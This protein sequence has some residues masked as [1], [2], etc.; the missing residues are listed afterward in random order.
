LIVASATGLENTVVVV[1]D[2]LFDDEHAAAVAP[3]TTTATI[4]ANKRKEDVLRIVPPGPF[5][6]YENIIPQATP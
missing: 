5:S 2:E 3:K 6:I 4:A 1:E